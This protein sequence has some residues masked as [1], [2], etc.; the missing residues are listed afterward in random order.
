MTS[1]CSSDLSALADFAG[2]LAA[3]ARAETLPMFRTQMSVDDK[4]GKSHYDP[5]TA[6]D[7]AAERAMRD[8]IA[9][10]YPDHSVCGEE[11]DDDIGASPYKWLLDPIDG[12]K[13][14]IVG[15]PV[16]ATLIGL[17]KDDTPVVGIMDQPFIGERFTGVPGRSWLT[18]A[19]G[20]YALATR[21]LTNL[22]DAV[23]ASTDPHNLRTP[24]EE[25]RFHHLR[26]KV[27]LSRYGGDAYFYCLLAAGHI[28]I[29]M[30][31]GMGDYDIAALIPIVENAGGVVST[32]TGESAQ[33]GGNI[34]ASANPVLHETVLETLAG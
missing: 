12:T 21:Q 24:D 9:A 4:H 29:V 23:L 25:A 31:P 17:L 10:H 18:N 30:D 16:W 8:H 34:L 1:E 22:G 15:M 32:W 26:S 2:D 28:D 20:E 6:A 27:R 3:I 33:R 5:V 19:H 11:F 14:F 7:R 13:A